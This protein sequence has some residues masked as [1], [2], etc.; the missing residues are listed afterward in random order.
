[1]V[2]LVAGRILDH[3]HANVSHVLCTPSRHTGFS[4]TFA[5]R[6]KVPIDDEHWGGSHYHV[7][8]I[9]VSVFNR[10]LSVRVFL[11]RGVAACLLLLLGSVMAQQAQPAAGELV[12]SGKYRLYKFGQAIGEET[13]EI[14][15]DGAALVL[16]DKFL[17]TDRGSPVP[18]DTM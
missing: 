13:F 8:S 7:H 5:G 2:G 1:M 12:E 10:R 6:H 15:R 11:R 3:A 16:T 17:F 18:L 9:F 14:R 4:R